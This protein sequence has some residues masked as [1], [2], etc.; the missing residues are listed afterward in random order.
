MLYPQAHIVAFEA[1]PHI[2][3]FLQK[4]IQSFQYKNVEVYNK[5]VW[6]KDD[7]TLSFLEEGGA[8][9]RIEQEGSTATGNYIHVQTSRLKN[10]LNTHVNFLKI[11]IE[12]AEYSVIADCAENLKNVENLFIEWH[13]FANKKQDLHEILSIVHEAGFI[14]HIQP[15]FFR[16][17]PFIDRNVNNGMDLQLNIFCYRN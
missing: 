16:K 15:A 5:A 17:Q 13:G 14:Y 1:D 11:D 12:G 3:H 9:G 7:E 6:N 8:G 4:N 10:Y 2:F